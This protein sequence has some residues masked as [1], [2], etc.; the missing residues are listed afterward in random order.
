MVV[1]FFGTVFM[2]EPIEIGSDGYVEVESF[3]MEHR[4]LEFRLS[5]AVFE[6]MFGL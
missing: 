6:N 1:N 4:Y 2:K 3:E 5:S